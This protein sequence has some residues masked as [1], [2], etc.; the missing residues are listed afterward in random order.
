MSAIRAVPGA[1]GVA[2]V[3]FGLRL[4]AQQNLI[5]FIPF[6]VSSSGIGMIMGWLSV[7]YGLV[8][9]IAAHLVSD[10]VIDGIPRLAA[11]V[12]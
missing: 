7:R 5:L 2:A 6:V 10:L 11:V 4:D 8:S 9:A 1:C 3:E 12:A